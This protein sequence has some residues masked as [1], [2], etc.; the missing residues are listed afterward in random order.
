MVKKKKPEIVIS[1]GKR[2]SSVARAKIV[3]GSG[4]VRI[5]SKP[6]EL[7]GTE[8][9]RMKIMEPLVLASD[10]TKK[11]DIEVNV[12]GGGVTGQTDATRTAIAKGLVE[13]FKS[14]ELKQKFLQYDRNLLVSDMRR[15][16]PRKPS[17]SRK[18]SRRHKQRSKR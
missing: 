2:K 15:A 8:L 13:F 5:N 9:L 1:V 18:G 6:L 11:V 17:R 10:L 3:T 14:K 7:W 12:N 4:K 16:E